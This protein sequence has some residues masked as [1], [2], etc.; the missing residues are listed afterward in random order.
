MKSKPFSAIRYPSSPL[1]RQNTT[2]NIH[3]PA[4]RS[5]LVSFFLFVFSLT[6]V[7]STPRGT[8]C[9]VAVALLS[10]Y[11]SLVFFA[12][13]ENEKRQNEKKSTE[14]ERERRKDNRIDERCPNANKIT[15]ARVCSPL[16]TTPFVWRARWQGSMWKLFHFLFATRCRMWRYVL[17]WTMCQSFFKGCTSSL[18][19]WSVCSLVFSLLSSNNYVHKFFLSV[20]QYRIFR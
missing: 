7:C 18:R 10:T 4:A 17:E 19:I 1:S 8:F 16:W 12:S 5:S 11:I 14:I 9:S 15:S 20:V 2:T 3:F 6:C 13:R